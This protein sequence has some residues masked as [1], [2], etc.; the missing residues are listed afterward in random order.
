MT[1]ASAAGPVL[2]EA[3]DL[4][5]IAFRSLLRDTAPGMVRDGVGP[6]VLFY[7]GWRLGGLTH[8]RLAP[9]FLGIALATVA[10]IG[11]YLLA[12]HQGREGALARMSLV[13]VLLQAVVGAVTHSA[14]LYL[15][16]PIVGDALF[17][18][19][20]IGSVVIGRPLIAWIARDVFPFPPEVVASDTFR[21][22]YSR[23]TLAWAVYFAARGLIR[24]A[25][26]LTGS[27]EQVLLVLVLSDAPMV[28]AMITWSVWYSVRSFRRSAEWGQ[29]I[30]VVDAARRQGNALA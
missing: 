2:P 29:A 24:L 25:A 30:A 11:L 15:A 7:A 16:R 8:Q 27:L 19:V 20:L 3:A 23:I 10:G 14:R 18:A 13:L 1:A 5:P 17:F 22:V 26:L 12:R 28:I 6:F 9:L 21:H 4:P